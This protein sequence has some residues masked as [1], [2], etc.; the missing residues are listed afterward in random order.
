MSLVEKQITG[1]LD[2]AIEGLLKSGR[3]PD[4][5]DFSIGDFDGTPTLL[6]KKQGA[7]ERSSIE[8]INTNL[9]SV[10]GDLEVLFDEQI[11]QELLVGRQL[12]ASDNEFR[13]LLNEIRDLAI[14]SNEIILANDIVLSLGAY[15]FDD[16]SSLK[17]VDTKRTT[18]VVDVD[19]TTVRLPVRAVS[20]IALSKLKIKPSIAVWPAAPSREIGDFSSLLTETVSLWVL[21][22]EEKGDSVNTTVTID[23]DIRDR[24]REGN[25]FEF[26][27][28]VIG[29]PLSPSDIGMAVL[30]KNSFTPDYTLLPTT[31]INGKDSRTFEVNLGEIAGWTDTPQI[32]RYNKTNI[33][34]LRII[35][36]KHAPD[37]ITGSLYVHYFP[38]TSI[39][40]YRLVYKNNATL[41]SRS[42]ELNGTK[43]FTLHSATLAV[44]GTA[45]A[46]S[47]VDFCIAEDRYLPGYFA[48]A[49]DEYRKAGSPD[50]TKVISSPPSPTGV[51]Q[52]E[53]RDWAILNGGYTFAG[54][55]Y[56]N[57]EPEWKKIAPIEGFSQVTIGDVGQEIVNFG[58]AMKVI[59][60]GV[61]WADPSGVIEDSVGGINFYR[62]VEFF[63]EPILST[64]V[65]RQGRDTWK[66]TVVRTEGGEGPLGGDLDDPTWEAKGPIIRGSVKNVRT[67]NG[68]PN[69]YYIGSGANAQYYV[70]YFDAPNDNKMVIHP[71]VFVGGDMPNLGDNISFTVNYA[72]PETVVTWETYFYLEEGERGALEIDSG[73]ISSATVIA[74]SKEGGMEVDRK[75]LDEN[76]YVNFTEVGQS[77]GWYKVSIVARSLTWTP[78]GNVVIYGSPKQWCWIAPLKTIPY[79]E[80]TNRTSASDHT[81]TAVHFPDDGRYRIQ[82]DNTSSV[83]LAVNDPTYPSDQNEKRWIQLVNPNINDGAALTAADIFANRNSISNFYSLSYTAIGNLVDHALVKFELHTKDRNVTPVID[84]YSIRVVSA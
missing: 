44:G 68:P 81:A 17:K 8:T 55:D 26:N 40:L 83:W 27:R 51:L 3:I 30:Y 47:G 52:T 28:L 45:P 71:N 63:D 66:K 65:L 61:S 84:G 11:D 74:Y 41:V 49:S 34:N 72:D 46:G 2:R 36:T 70:K 59:G 15:S 53:L 77:S 16:F 56:A 1:A 54:E 75:A 78:V 80:L 58:N 48:N 6:P 14:E 24:S 21:R 18:A 10:I 73:T 7:R 39:S 43:A 32:E 5:M 79:H 69:E 64:V 20:K 67:P 29:S 9:M 60:D 33:T 22:V 31:I 76:N 57:W 35:L 13:K 25:G 82:A 38:L 23:I 50:I 19:D 62:V 42:I 4:A 37:E 12:A